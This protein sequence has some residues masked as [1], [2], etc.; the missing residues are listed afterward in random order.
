MRAVLLVVTLLALGRVASA[1]V[2]VTATVDP[3]QI[4]AGESADLA[5][6]VDGTQNAPT[7]EVGSAGGLQVRYVGPASQVSFTN[8]RLTASITHHFTVLAAKAGR[9]TIGPI[10]VD[11]DGKR[12]DAGSVTLEVLAAG[13]T[14]SS[15]SPNG[16][17]QVEL[18]LALPR[19]DVYLHEHLPL[20]V[21][22]LVGAVRVGDLQYPVVA[23]D[24]FSLEKF[25]EPSQHREETPHGTRQA[26]EFTTTLT[27]LKTGTLT[28]GPATVRMSLLVQGRRRGGFFGGFFGD[29]SRPL[30]LQ[31]EAITLTVLPLPS[32]GRPAD[33][34]GAVGR[35]TF[36][37]T[38]SPTDVAAGDPVTVRSVVRGEGSLDGISAPTIA[39]SDTVRVYR[40][41]AA[42]PAD[43]E[44]TFEQVVIPLRDGPLTLPA[45]RFSYFDPTS[46]SYRTLA[47]ARIAL[48]VRPST[49][50]QASPQIVGGAPAPLPQRTETLE[51]DIV[52]IKDTPGTLQPLGA[53][54]QR[55]P[56]WWALQ[57]VPVALWGIAATYDRR[58][59]RLATDSRY[60]RFTRAG[61]EARAALA[62]AR[63]AFG[64]GDTA[65]CHDQIA[66]A[67]R[68]YLAAKLALSPGRVVETAPERL[69]SDGAGDGLA[70]QVSSFFA[71]CEAAR[72][73]PGGASPSE[74]E[75]ALGQADGIVRALERMRLSGPA[76]VGL[77]LLALGLAASAIAAGE[78]GPSAL[79]YRGNGLYSE[80]RYA[81]A[82]ATYERVLAAGVESAA[83]HFNLGNAYFKTGDVGR[84]V[85]AY[86]RAARRAPGDPDL[87]A[88]LAYARERASDVADEPI[89]A[90]L[91]VPLAPRASTNTLLRAAGA[92]WW[93]LW[94][95]LATA[96]IVS[97]VAR[98]ARAIAVAAAVTFAITASAAGYRWWTI[99]HPTYAVVVARDDATVRYEPNPQAKAY[100]AAKPGTVLRVD[101]EQRGWSQVVGRDGRRG[102]VESPALEAV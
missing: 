43:G 7:P 93:V 100:F 78:E 67:I 47:P 1:D 33:F 92:S 51:R 39:A 85:L 62:E 23:G 27:P 84:A 16:T 58:R 90:R 61:R 81:D 75:Q 8:G 99:E 26:A 88:N 36:D 9:Y 50:A 18:S 21:K 24:G 34:S 15:G 40:V 48:T 63:D 53:G 57:L 56:G 82:A 11:V 42:P 65:A 73:A 19:T 102:W 101:G 46:R 31:S 4:A 72:F 6:T 28:I 13:A 74:L 70:T 86:E 79:F 41:Q 60:A 87:A 17:D 94:L 59:R 22:L 44:R 80:G 89:A 5:V 10:T 83:V 2:H 14:R 30:Q 49:Q 76:A 45:L 69:R 95:A 97:G 91:L 29:E 66:A 25:L 35:F 3:A 77:V 64:R 20:T 98:G 32:E 96:P 12:H 37:V 52:F 68:D 54:R 71:A 38:A 55:N